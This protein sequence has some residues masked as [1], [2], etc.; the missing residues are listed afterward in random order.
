MT[1]LYVQTSGD[2]DLLEPATRFQVHEELFSLLRRN[3]IKFR[4]QHL[5]AHLKRESGSLGSKPL[6]RVKLNLFTDQGKY[7]VEEEGFGP[8]A[9]LRN[10]MLTLRYQIERDLEIKQDH[11]VPG[12]KALPVES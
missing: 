11:R 5:N 6:M 2:F 4:E 3:R 9:A 8:D 7:H 10:A 1:Y 12:R